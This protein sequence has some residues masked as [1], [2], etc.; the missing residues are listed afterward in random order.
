MAYTWFSFL[1]AVSALIIISRK[2][3][4]VALLTG[5]AILGFM[6][7]PA[8]EVLKI[9]TD[10][11]TDG[12]ILLLAISVGLIP[13]IGGLLEESGLINRL[14]DSIWIR[15]KL[16][17]MIAP[18]FMGMLIMPGGALLSAPV[19]S[20]AGGKIPG[21]DYAALNVWFRHVLVMIYP[22]AA[23]LPTTKM[24]DLDLYTQVLYLLPGFVLLTFLGYVFLLRSVEQGHSLKGKFNIKKVAPP[25]IIVL[26]APVLHILLIS[27]FSS[28]LPELA[29]LIS[30]CVSLS[31][32]FYFGKIEPAQLFPL[33]QGVR[34]WKYFLIIIGMFALLHIFKAS[35]ASA[36]IAAIAFSQT[37]LIVGVGF[38][39]G[40]VTGRVQV[41][42]SILLPI[43]FA[44]YGT[45]Q[46]THLVFTLMF[47]AVFMGYVFSP[48]HPCVA[49]SLEYFKTDIKQ[50]YK[51]ISAP[52]FITLA[53]VLFVS[54]ILVG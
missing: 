12:S 49:V 17:L 8:K 21:S 25:I 7:L 52:V 15:V 14:I 53:I 38:F 19:I 13:I 11:L 27:F 16:F 47:I 23:L 6:N 37:F 20:K 40:F 46:M 10:T 18:A 31:L 45:A 26:T 36:A 28:I 48:V 44:K 54:I 22:L 34:P 50:F 32:G 29:L 39:L 4:W 30:V 1:L 41:P 5:A 42:V 3:L 51:R 33:V 43:F 2:S 9:F 24:A 35:D